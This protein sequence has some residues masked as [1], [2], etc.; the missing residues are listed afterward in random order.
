LRACERTSGLANQ[1]NDALPARAK[2][3]GGDLNHGSPAFLLSKDQN[4]QQ[5]QSARDQDEDR[6]HHAEN[7]SDLE[8]HR[9]RLRLQ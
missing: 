3:E 5:K 8:L 2:D 7:V 9:T 6:E 1:L 4:A